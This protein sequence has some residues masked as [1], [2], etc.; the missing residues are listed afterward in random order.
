MAPKKHSGFM[1]YVAEFRRKKG[2]G[3][4][5]SIPQAVAHCG[6]IWK[7]M[8][9]QQR[10]PYISGAKNAGVVARARPRAALNCHGE[11]IDAREKEE[12]DAAIEIGTMKRDIERMVREGKKRLDLENTKFMFVS[13]NYFV[14]AVNTD[15]YIPAEFSACEFSLKTGVNSLYS[16]MIDPSQLIFGQTCDAMLYAAATHQLPLPPAALGESKM[17]KLYHSIQDYLRSRLERTDKNLKSLVVFT[18]T[19]DIDMVKSCFRF[20]KS[21][22]HDEQSKRYDDDNDEEN[23]QFKFFEAAASKFLPI[24]VYD[25]QYLFLALKLAAMDIGGLTLPKPN[26]YI[27][28]AFFSR[29]FYEFQDGIA[30]WFHEDM[31]R[32]KYCTQSKVKRW[33]YTFCDYMC[34]DL[35]IKMQPGKHMPPSYKATAALIKFESDASVDSFFSLRTASALTLDTEDRDQ[36][37]PTPSIISTVGSLTSM[38]TVPLLEE[39]DTASSKKLRHLTYWNRNAR[40]TLK[41]CHV[42]RTERNDPKFLETNQSVDEFTD[43]EFNVSISDRTWTL[44]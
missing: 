7:N 40:R 8:T 1:M 10:G 28:D 43:D 39:S 27:T 24:V 35:A 32:S 44:T 30:C 23:D 22:Y 42:M 3:Q 34:A 29:D 21:G 31:D 13:F 11:A 19:D 25:I 12:R 14:K 37:S 33:A 38:N 36:P 5:M 16:T 41:K 17:T 18:K 20:I 4:R 15:I 9:D 2:E 6:S 26:L